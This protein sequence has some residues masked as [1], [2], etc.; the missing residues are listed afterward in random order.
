MALGYSFE[1]YPIFGSFLTLMFP[2]YHKVSH[3]ET[4]CSHHHGLL[5]DFRPQA[6]KPA[7]HSPKSVKP[8]TKINLYL[9]LT[10]SPKNP[11][12]NQEAKKEKRKHREEFV[13]MIKTFSCLVISKLIEVQVEAAR[14]NAPHSPQI[15][16]FFMFIH[17]KFIHSYLFR[18]QFF[19]LGFIALWWERIHNFNLSEF[20]NI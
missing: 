9:S 15:F 7:N 11:A 18:S 14:Q 6:L 1:K 17:W 3:S 8:W 2:R 12:S 19:Y 4:L 13:K 20:V 10:V 5:A 16:Y